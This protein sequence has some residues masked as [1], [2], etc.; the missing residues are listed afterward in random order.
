MPILYSKGVHKIDKSKI[1]PAAIFVIKTLADKGYTTYLVGGSVRDLLC[2]LVPKDFDVGTSA[3][4]FE[5]KRAFRDAIMIGKRFPIVHVRVG[6]KVIEVATFRKGDN[7]CPL[8]VKR[9]AAWGTPE[10]DARKRDFT[11]NALFYDPKEETILDFVGGF[12]DS[13]NGILRVIGDPIKR[14]KQDPVRM[15]RL[16]R[17]EARGFSIDEESRSAIDHCKEHICNS[18]GPR[19]LDQICMMMTKGS[20][21]FF[22]SICSSGIMKTLFPLASINENQPK[23]LL[24]IIKAIESYKRQQ[25]I[26]KSIL[27]SL[28]YIS[29]YGP[30]KISRETR[31]S[32]QSFSK[33][34][35]NLL[36]GSIISISKKVI[37]N[38]YNIV[39]VCS[40]FSRKE[41][42]KIQQ[43]KL[44][45][46]NIPQAF[47]TAKILRRAFPEMR[48]IFSNIKK[49]Y[50]LNRSRPIE[51]KSHKKLENEKHDELQ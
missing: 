24:K 8:L 12:N 35:S 3:R 25:D 20:E 47:I 11:I 31:L 34:I 42:V 5:V 18:A 38:A 41:S 46:D 28:V 49:Y 44:Y 40:L 14:F 51:R 6:K 23:N 30:E 9:D 50:N 26:D 22:Q 29:L 16:F 2:N 7:N 10:Q 17:F 21:K 37:K 39:A 48:T 36:Q 43:N 13:K 45:K 27:L 32:Y 15:L 1:D 19:I 33:F 4:P